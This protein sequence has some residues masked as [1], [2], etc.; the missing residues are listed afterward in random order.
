MSWHFQKWFIADER[1]QNKYYNWNLFFTV[2]MLTKKTM[3]DYPTAI[4]HMLF[5]FLSQLGEL[6]CVKWFNLRSTQKFELMNKYIVTASIIYWCI[7]TMKDVLAF[8][9]EINK[10]NK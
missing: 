10:T 9:L 3:L 1:T 6:I 4:K 8:K 2:D 5:D 7:L